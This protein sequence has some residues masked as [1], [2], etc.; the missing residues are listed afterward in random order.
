M[1][2]RYSGWLLLL[3]CLFLVSC[4]D[5]TDSPDGI[6]IIPG[7]AV[8]DSA[9]SAAVTGAQTMPE[10]AAESVTAAETADDGEESAAMPDMDSALAAQVSEL[11]LD[12]VF[13]SQLE[14]YGADRDSAAAYLAA[15]LAYQQLRAEETGAETA[16]ADSD[17]TVFWTAGGSVWHTTEDCSALAKAKDIRSGT[18]AQALDMGKSRVCKRCGGS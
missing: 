10:T 12:E 9:A 15:F 18:E 2:I 4:G 7:A 17:G 11:L 5:V 8:Q 6:L 1:K 16:A 13:L 14:K 3:L